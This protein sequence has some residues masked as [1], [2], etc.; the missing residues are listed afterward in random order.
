MILK[1]SPQYETFV[2]NFGRHFLKTVILIVYLFG[3]MPDVKVEAYSII[4][5][6]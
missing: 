5:K 6:I 1:I 4:H 2:R 3:G